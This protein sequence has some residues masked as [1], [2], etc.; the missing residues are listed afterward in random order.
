MLVGG[1]DP[2]RHDLSAM[3]MLKDNHIWSTGSITNA[4]KAARAVAGFALKIEVE[5]QTEEDAAEAADA[6]AD[7]IMLDNFGPEGVRT[8]AARLKEKWRAQGLGHVL[9]ECSGGLSEENFKDYLCN[10]AFISLLIN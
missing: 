2:H 1:I 10:G 7:V 4:V 8:A 6:G 9:L 3:V 5:C